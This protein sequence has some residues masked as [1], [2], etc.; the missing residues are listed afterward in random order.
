MITKLNHKKEDVS[1][2]IYRVFQASYRIEAEL[3]QVPFQDFPPLKRTV[4]GF[5]ESTTNFYGF[6]KASELAAVIE[7]DII[8]NTT[9]ICSLIVHPLYFRQGIAKELLDFAA[10]L[11]KSEFVIVET[12]LANKPA[13]ALYETFGFVLLG[14][15]KTSIGIEKVT[16]SLEKSNLT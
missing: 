2:E 16:F 1:K 14:K 8:N 5:Q 12:G 10:K 9:D 3:L 15:Y 7:I 13:I 4:H 11:H 6:F